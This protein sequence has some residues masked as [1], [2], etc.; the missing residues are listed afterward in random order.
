MNIVEKTMPLR[1]SV[2]L[3]ALR[4]DS[5][6]WRSE[7]DNLIVTVGKDALAKLL[8][9]NRSQNVTK[10][11]VG[12]NGAPTNASDTALANPFSKP[13]EA[14]RYNGYTGAWYGNSV[15]VSAGQLRCEWILLNSEANGL[16]IR[17][18]G[19]L[20]SD[21]VLFARYVRPPSGGEP[22]TILKQSDMTLAGA[23]TINCGV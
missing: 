4:G 16:A 2:E 19:L 12:T 17:E 14:K 6:L 11:S 15:N 21:D 18:F 1:G 13:L 23:W 22:D 8:G 3:V 5:V 7:T 10:I 20:F 9:G